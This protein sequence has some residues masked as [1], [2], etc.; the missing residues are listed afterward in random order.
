MKLEMCDYP[1]IEAPKPQPK[2]EP[3]KKRPR[4]KAV[5]VEPRKKVTNN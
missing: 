1:F 5:K 2:K 3:K 4:I